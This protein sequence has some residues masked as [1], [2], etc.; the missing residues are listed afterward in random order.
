M[1]RPS[2]TLDAVLTAGLIGMVVALA[3]VMLG[4]AFLAGYAVGRLLVWLW[5]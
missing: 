4:W 3:L 2:P 5:G 1:N